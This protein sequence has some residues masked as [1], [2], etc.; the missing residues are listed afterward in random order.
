MRLIATLLVE[1][2]QNFLDAIADFLRT[3]PRIRI[4]VHPHSDDGSPT[5]VDEQ[6][7]DLVLDIDLPDIA[8]LEAVRRIMMSVHAPRVVILTMHDSQRNDPHRHVSYGRVP[9][10]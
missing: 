10:A 2:Q 6:T 5:K 7:V 9:I 4:T 8:G 1:D 3:E